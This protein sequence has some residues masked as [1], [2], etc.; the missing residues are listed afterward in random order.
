[1]KSKILAISL[2]LLFFGSIATTSVAATVYQGNDVVFA[3]MDNDK[4][5]DKD[6]KKSKASEKKSG[7]CADKSA[8][9]EC[10]SKSS[11]KKTAS[12]DKK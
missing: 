12:N 2:S 3:K 9:S 11:G 10:C 5:K 1:M 8:K 7:E 4:D 6:K